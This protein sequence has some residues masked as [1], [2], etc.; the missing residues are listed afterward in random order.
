MD[1]KE[2]MATFFLAAMFAHALRGSIDKAI[3]KELLAVNAFDCAQAFL[4]EAK[5]RGINLPK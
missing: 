2:Q 3:P 5:K 4:V 1:E